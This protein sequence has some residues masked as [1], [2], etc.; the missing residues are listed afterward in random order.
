MRGLVIV[1]LLVALSGCATTMQPPEPRELTL[2]AAPEATLQEIVGL[3]M[4]EGYVIRHADAEL[5]R[6]EAVLARW[7]GYRVR[8]EVT[9]I[10]QGARASLTATR[11]GIPLPPHLLDPLL[12]ELQRRLGLAPR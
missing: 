8:A 9:P 6:V 5:G 11:G 1:L 12:A 3:L 7:P 4:E 2:A 10:G